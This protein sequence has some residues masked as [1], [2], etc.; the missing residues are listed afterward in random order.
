MQLNL[1]T[2]KHEASKNGLSTFV[3]TKMPI[4]LFDGSSTGAFLG[5]CDATLCEV[6]IEISPRNDAVTQLRAIAAQ[7]EGKYGP[8]SYVEESAGGWQSLHA[9][10]VR[11]GEAL[12]HRSWRWADPSTGQQFSHLIVNYTCQRN[13]PSE[14]LAV[15]YQDAAMSQR[16]WDEAK[17]RHENF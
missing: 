6:N 2:G 17:R 16:R 5:F 9:T 8:P 10:C 7:L 12:A 1:V 4:D 13:P 14:G 11:E 3:C 15:I